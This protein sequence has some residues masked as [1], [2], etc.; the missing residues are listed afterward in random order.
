MLQKVFVDMVIRLLPVLDSVALLI[1]RPNESQAVL[2]EVLAV[3]NVPVD[4]GFGGE[5][6]VGGGDEDG[7]GD[8]RGEEFGERAA[9]LDHDIVRE[10]LY[11]VEGGR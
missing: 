10:G 5:D 8:V 2:D 3:G 6:L 9:T 11:D 7:V 4:R 1:S